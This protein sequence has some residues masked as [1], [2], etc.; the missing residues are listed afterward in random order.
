MK[1]AN[2]T[3]YLC[4]TFTVYLNISYC[5]NVMFYWMNM[6]NTIYLFCF[7]FVF[8]L[9]LRVLFGDW[10][11]DYVIN[12]RSCQCNIESYY[13]SK[14]DTIYHVKITTRYGDLSVISHLVIVWSHIDKKAMIWF[15]SSFDVT[16]FE[17]RL[18]LQSWCESWYRLQWKTL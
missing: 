10:W 7:V 12:Q 18:I 9:H 17:V 8:Y 1:F 5:W 3:I 16:L 13:F 2:I 11:Q 15:Y 6:R 14:Y 4:N